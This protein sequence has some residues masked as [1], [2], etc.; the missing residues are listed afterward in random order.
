MYP[1]IIRETEIPHKPVFD[2]HTPFEETVRRRQKKSKPYTY[3]LL[4]DMNHLYVSYRRSIQCSKWK[5][6]VQ[7]YE[8][9]S[10]YNLYKLYKKLIDQTYQQRDF[11][12]F[13]LNERGKQRRIKSMYIEDRIVQRSLS[14]FILTP[15]I[16]DYLIYDNPASLE[17]RGIDF[18]RN[19]LARHLHWF[20][21]KYQ[22]NGY[23]LKIDFSK[24]FDNLLHEYAIKVL[25]DLVV[26]PKVR[27]LISD[28]MDSFK[29]DVSYMDDDEY[30]Q[31]LLT[32]FN[33]LEYQF[34]SNGKKTGEKYLEKSVGI[35]SHM[36]Q[37]I[38]VLYPGEIDNYCKIVQRIKCY[39]RYMDDI[40]IIHPDKEYLIQL[41]ER[42]DHI[43]SSIGLC[44]NQKKTTITPLHRGFTYMQIRY[45]LTESGH[46]VRKPTTKAFA[47]ERRKL[48]SFKR[49]LECNRITYY[50][51]A[52]CYKSWR[53]NI[54]K[55]DSYRSLQSMDRYFYQ[56]FGMY[57][58][59]ICDKPVHFIPEDIGLG[60]ANYYFPYR[61]YPDLYI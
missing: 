61:T 2:I 11:Y 14:D 19:R 46:L 54:E 29:Q 6:S 34:L 47:R 21:R 28:I 57:Y 48:R 26:D 23:I 51:I 56:I 22:R 31:C 33:T 13:T 4:Y 37:I 55:F 52:N 25:Y 44:I 38:G 5:R 27:D 35:G 36:S 59:E 43:S 18:A 20:F 15:I 41:L 7:N 16:T 17:Q 12:E 3:G 10:V 1:I 39:G 45:Y 42:I 24:F 53:G 30:A 50:E 9:N 58:D 8:K 49:L 60:R 40:Y 32:T